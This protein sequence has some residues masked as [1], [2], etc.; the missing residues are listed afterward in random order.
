[1]LEPQPVTARVI[2]GH[3][4]AELVDVAAAYSSGLP[5]HDT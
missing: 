1:M 2:D 4:S 3:E 5:I